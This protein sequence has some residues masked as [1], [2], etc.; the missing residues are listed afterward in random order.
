MVSNLQLDQM[1]STEME[2]P[3]DYIQHQ[4]QNQ[5]GEAGGEIAEDDEIVP[6]ITRRGH[7]RFEPPGKGE[8]PPA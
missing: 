3:K 8:A 1:Q 7:I 2:M 6:I 5:N 4:D